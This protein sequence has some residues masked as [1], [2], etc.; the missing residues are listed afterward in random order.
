MSRF[1]LFLGGGG[2][3]SAGNTNA[4]NDLSLSV[5]VNAQAVVAAEQSREVLRPIL[6][7]PNAPK[8]AATKKRRI[9]ANEDRT[10]QNFRFADHI[11]NFYVFEKNH[12]FFSTHRGGVTRSILA[13][14]INMSLTQIIQL[15]SLEIFLFSE[16]TSEDTSKFEF[17]EC[18]RRSKS[19]ACL[20]PAEEQRFKELISRSVPSSEFGRLVWNYLPSE[21]GIKGITDVAKLLKLSDYDCIINLEN[22]TRWSPEV[23]LVISIVLSRL[24]KSFEVRSMFHVQ[25]ATCLKDLYKFCCLHRIELVRDEKGELVPANVHLCPNSDPTRGDGWI[26]VRTYR[27]CRTFFYHSN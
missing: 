20:N 4:S 21:C 11:P 7:N 24:A 26:H 17:L 25:S 18:Q 12:K 2:G 1:D 3:V 8:S 14:R 15:L 10:V 6:A 19:G 13:M 5:D 9:D 22:Y 23:F 16:G 27:A